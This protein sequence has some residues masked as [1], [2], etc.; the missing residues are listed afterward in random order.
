MAGT[1]DN[2][3][4]N[5]LKGLVNSLAQSV[6]TLAAR[7]SAPSDQLKKSVEL[8]SELEFQQRC[9]KRERDCD[10]KRQ[11][12]VRQQNLL[13]ELQTRVRRVTA[14]VETASTVILDDPSADLSKPVTVKRGSLADTDEGKEILVSLGAA[15]KLLAS[16]LLDLSVVCAAS[17]NAVGWSVVEAL[18][19]A[20]WRDYCT[21]EKHALVVKDTLAAQEKRASDA[22]DR[23]RK[24][25]DRKDRGRGRGGGFDNSEGYRSRKAHRA[26]SEYAAGDVGSWNTYNGQYIPPPAGAPPR[27]AAPGSAAGGMAANRSSGSFHSQN[28]FCYKCTQPGHRSSNCP[29]P[30]APGRF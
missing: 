28:D 24:D 26:G 7:Q 4:M 2:A 30:P 23:D 14:T 29:N 21:D 8:T 1:E 10:S 12:I 27:S 13:D 3:E 6:Q 9:I 16:R 17:T 22:Y 18:T 15:D 19:G 20:S 25:R 11:G 5:V